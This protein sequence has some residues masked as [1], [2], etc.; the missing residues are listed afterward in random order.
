M[1]LLGSRVSSTSLTGTPEPLPHTLNPSTS[2][3]R[4][5]E[6]GEFKGSLVYAVGNLVYFVCLFVLSC[7]SRQ[8]F[9]V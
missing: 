2:R 5:A 7:V 1:A 4:Q 8:G 9:S 3:Q 6:L